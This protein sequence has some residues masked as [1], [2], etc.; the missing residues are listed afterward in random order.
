MMTLWLLGAVLFVGTQDP[1]Q[2][3]NDRGATM[4]GF[5]QDK[6]AH[7]FYLFDDGGAIDIVVKDPA[8][9]KNRDGIRSHLPHI[10]TMFGMGDFDVPML[11]HDDKNVPGTTVLAKRKD[12]VTYRYAETPLGGRV[13]IVTKDKDALTAL[14]EFL[15]YQIKEH[16]T[17]DSTVVTKRK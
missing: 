11:V 2:A 17:G 16:S 12:F 9:V 7:H 14:H 5:D 4:M 10:A 13:D 3:M 8:D 6:T 1:H 15:T